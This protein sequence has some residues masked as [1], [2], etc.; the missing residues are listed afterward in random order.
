MISMIDSDYWCITKEKEVSLHPALVSN[1]LSKAKRGI[2]VINYTSILECMLILPF[3]GNHILRRE[4]LR[5][6]SEE[7]Q[8]NPSNPLSIEEGF[9]EGCFTVYYKDIHRTG[10]TPLFNR[11]GEKRP[12]FILIRNSE[13]NSCYI[14][15]NGAICLKEFRVF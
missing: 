10:M 11:L 3:Y 9:P 13:E 1:L 15:E 8:S 6:A 2:I 5:R 4:E 12:V 14:D 7:M